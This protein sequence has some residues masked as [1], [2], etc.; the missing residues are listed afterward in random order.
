MRKNLIKIDAVYD[1]LDN[2]Q[3]Q[4]PDTLSK[5][6]IKDIEKA[7]REI[8]I[9]RENSEIGL[10]EK[11]E[12]RIFWCVVIYVS[13]VLLVILMQGFGDV[14]KF[15]HLEAPVLIALLTTTTANILAL[16]FLIIK[17]LFHRG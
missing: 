14:F 11:Y 16:L 5:A 7:A 13:I 15:F 1:K 6:A 8:A 17:Y 3:T 9:K 12:R 10:R 4:E 2:S